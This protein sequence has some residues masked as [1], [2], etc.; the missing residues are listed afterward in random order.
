MK[1]LVLVMGLMLLPAAAFAQDGADVCSKIGADTTTAPPTPPPTGKK[2]KARPDKNAN[3]RM[4]LSRVVC[5]V[6]QTLDAYQQSTEVDDKTLPKLA[7]AD[8]DFK[9]TV[10]NKGGLTFSFL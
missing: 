9:T 4:L 10:D 7:S 3:K 8:F 2:S 5:E 6:E 1:Q